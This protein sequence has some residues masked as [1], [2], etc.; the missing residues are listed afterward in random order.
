MA[1][2]PMLP[3]YK[4]EKPPVIDGVI[5][6]SEWA[7]VPSGSGSFDTTNGDK[8]P[9]PMKFWLAFDDKNIYFAANM[10]DSQPRTIKAL[11]YDTN[12]SLTGDDNV[13]LSLDLG[14]SLANYNVFAI[15]PRGATSVTLE[16]GRASKLEWTGE[17]VA[18]GRITPTGW[19]VE[20]RIPWQMIHLPK[21]GIRDVRFNVTR[22]MPRTQRQYSWGFVDFSKPS[23]VPIWHSIPIPV[24]EHQRLLKLLPYSYLGYDPRVGAVFNN[25]LD[26]KAELTD[27]M[28]FVGTIN[29]DFRNIADQVLSLDFSRFERLPGESRPFFLEGSQFMSSQIYNSQQIQNVD[30]GINVYGRL[31]DKTSFGI[32]ETSR[33]G[34]ENDFVSNLS[35]DPN[36]KDSYRITISSLDQPGIQSETY[37]ARYSRQVGPVNLF[38]RSMGSEDTAEG[39]GQFETA[40]AFFQKK[41]WFGLVEY[42]WA[43]PRFQARLGLIPEIDF[44]G[45]TYVGSYDKVYSKGPIAETNI[46]Y[47][48]TEYTHIDGT[49]YRRH[50]EVDSTISLRNRALLTSNYYTEKFNGVEDHLSQLAVLYPRDDTAR[51][52]SVEYDHGTLALIPYNS[53]SFTSSYRFGRRMQAS[54]RYQKVHHPDAQDQLIATASYDL[55][56]KRSISGRIIKSNSN[57]NGFISLQQTGNRGV[58]YFL[59]LGDPN[60]QRFVP[61]IILKIA[62]PIDVILCR[63]QAAKS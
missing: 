49:Q 12:V 46:G 59:I 15:N 24:Q 61:S 39:S 1:A 13:Q 19:E 22:I 6:E 63:K 37:L 4:M 62:V 10:G 47:N 27:K 11:Q 17:L 56:K 36:P 29:P 28:T 58:E 44:R 52:F 57:I 50:N 33:I 14:G 48:G 16:G 41:E 35:F 43:S 18:K 3:G 26:M 25:G 32:I 55:L 51:N 34:H 54:L 5:N 53:L 45:E 7:N 23:D 30:A 9:E 31:S 60:A 2:P 42:D 8:A 21:P 38:F 40:T 20:T